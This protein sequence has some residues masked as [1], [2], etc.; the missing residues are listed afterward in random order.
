MKCNQRCDHGHIM[1]RGHTYYLRIIDSLFIVLQMLCC[2]QP[3]TL[4]RISL[5]Q[6]HWKMTK[7]LKF[8]RVTLKFV[9]QHFQDKVADPHF[10]FNLWKMFLKRRCYVQFFKFLFISS[11][12]TNVYLFFKPILHLDLALCRK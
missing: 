5:H 1:W 8:G 11:F 9:F 4:H 3:A 2:V 7:P 12:V 10:C 6:E